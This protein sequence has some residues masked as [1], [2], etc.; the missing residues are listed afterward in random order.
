[1]RKS[2][3]AETERCIRG[4][5]RPRIP[6]LD[7]QARIHAPEA[8]RLI[9][10]RRRIELSECEEALRIVRERAQRA[11]RRILLAR[12]IVASCG[13]VV[14][15]RRMLRGQRVKSEIRLP[16]RPELLVHERHDA[17]HRR[18]RGGC[19]TCKNE[20]R[21]SVHHHTILGK[22]ADGVGAVVFSCCGKK[23]NVGKMARAV[24]RNSFAALP[25]RLRIT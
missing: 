13:N 18:R 19:A 6:V 25:R 20:P 11:G 3:L 16:L 4:R 12:H 15:N 17:G 9:V 23:G 1:M 21:S 7:Q 5:K 24:R 22:H 14:K 2:R 10:S 8:R